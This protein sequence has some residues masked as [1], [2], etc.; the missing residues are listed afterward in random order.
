VATA[1]VLVIAGPVAPAQ[2]GAPE[3][4]N[5][6]PIDTGE[7]RQQAAGQDEM[8]NPVDVSSSRTGEGILGEERDISVSDVSGQ[9]GSEGVQVLFRQIG[10][11]LAATWSDD[12]LHNMVGTV[13][14]DGP[15]G[16]PTSVNPTGLGGLDFTGSGPD[17]KFVLQVERLDHPGAPDATIV[18]VTLEVYTDA[19]NFSSL[20]MQIEG[21]VQVGNT[22]TFE[23]PIASFV[24]VAGGGVNWANVG[25][26]SLQIDTGYNGIDA[27][28]MLITAFTGPCFGPPPGGPPTPPPPEVPPEVPPGPPTPPTVRVPPRFTG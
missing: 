12:V 18:P 11:G 2:G 13:I 16:N 22:Q 8:G 14:Y 10:G 15:D 27:V 23:F 19:A 4:C 3:G 21:P 9:T 26:I 6:I 25:A 17:G 5:P 1:G 24:A 28:D 20:S 7:T